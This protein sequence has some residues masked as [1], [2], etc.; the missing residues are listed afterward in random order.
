MTTL[1]TH[2]LKTAKTFTLLDRVI[3]KI[4]LIIV[5]LLLA[6]LFP[7]LTSLHRAYYLALIVIAK[8]YFIHK[9][10]QTK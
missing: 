8:L 3:V 10:S 6:K 4:Y 9:M 5:G 1:I 7:I 2:A